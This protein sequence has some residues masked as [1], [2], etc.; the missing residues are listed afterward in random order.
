MTHSALSDAGRLWW[1]HAEPASVRTSSR[2]AGSIFVGMWEDLAARGRWA[3]GFLLALVL[4]AGCDSGAAAVVPRSAAMPDAAA[5]TVGPLFRNGTSAA[6]G[7]T[8]SILDSAEQ[9]LIITAAHCLVGSGAGLEFAPGYHDGVTPYGVWTVVAAFA[10]SAWISR[11]DPDHD[12]AILRV[13]AR[14]QSGK[15]VEVEAVA[16]GNRIGAAPPAGQMVT[17]IAYNAG[18]NDRPVRCATAVRDEGGFPAF[19]C[20][21]FSGGTSGGPWLTADD[22]GF[23]V[24]AV[25]GGPHYGGCLPSTSYSSQ[26]GAAIVSLRDAVIAGAAASIMPHPTGDGC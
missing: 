24:R 23:T 17:V 1:R 15:Q 25:I 4:C 22:A 6:H 16:G 18:L 21:G 3:L 11:Q 20:P 7:C 10:D 19:D 26:F 8:A 14:T 9:D 5:A 12:Y 2:G 13:A